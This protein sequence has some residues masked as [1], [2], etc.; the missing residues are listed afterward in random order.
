MPTTSAGERIDLT[1]EGVRNWLA[2]EHNAEYSRLRRAAPH[3]GVAQLALAWSLIVSSC[4]AVVAIG[5]V[6]L[7]LLPVALVGIGSSQRALNN[8]LHDAAHHNYGRWS[9]AMSTIFAA[10]PLF[11]SFD[12]YRARHQKHHR[13]LGKPRNDPDYLE[14]PR[15]RSSSPAL[16]A[17][18]FYGYFV[19]NLE[20]WTVSLGGAW[21]ALNGRRRAAVLLWWLIVGST[22][23]VVVGVHATLGSVAM[24][25]A[26]R[27]TSYHVIRVFADV[28]DHTGL[29][30]SRI[31]SGTRDLPLSPI[32]MVSHPWN[33]QHHL[34]HHLAPGVVS[35]RLRRLHRLLVAIPDYSELQIDGYVWGDRPLIATLGSNHSKSPH[36]QKNKR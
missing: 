14:P 7:W 13:F 21:G 23:L 4:Y 18:E 2:A 5:E 22:L 28:S 9:R 33:D 17:L 32:S 27:A 12:V 8:V 11:E 31:A 36:T 6:W 30:Q 24:W 1:P 3:I 16:R 26:S 15:Q 20:Q 19:F 25:V 34:A 35:Y 10:L 29:D